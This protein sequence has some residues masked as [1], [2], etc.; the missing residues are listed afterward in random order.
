MNVL[1]TG[2]GLFPRGAVL[3][4]L[5]FLDQLPA[6]F[7]C[8]FFSSFISF[9]SYLLALSLCLLWGKVQGLGLVPVAVTTSLALT[10]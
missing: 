1:V 7:S 10:S 2:T 4:P 5:L 6:G 8:C 3:P 9:L